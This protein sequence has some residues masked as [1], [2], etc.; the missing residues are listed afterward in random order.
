M[1]LD[2]F[3]NALATALMNP[4]VQGSS[5]FTGFH[6]SSAS[7]EWVEEG[8]KF[9]AGG[10]LRAQA[11][12][13]AGVPPTNPGTSQNRFK[14]FF[15]DCI[16][17]GI[18]E[19]AKRAGIWRGDEV[20]FF[21]PGTEELPPVKGRTDL[22]IADPVSN[23]PVGVEVKSSGGYYF[24]KA[25]LGSEGR[26]KIED[27]IQSLLYLDCYRQW[28][29]ALWL[30]FYLDREQCEYRTYGVEIG[31]GEAL[32]SGP[33]FREPWPHVN[34]ASIHGRW[35]RLRA[36]IDRRELPNR[37]YADQW[38]NDRIALEYRL[39]RLNQKDTREVGKKLDA[40][41]TEEPLIR[42]GDWNCA[43]CDHRDLCHG[44]EWHAALDHP[45]A[46]NP[47]DPVTFR[48]VATDAM[49]PAVLDFV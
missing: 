6:P 31:A 20:R 48:P 21:V 2:H 5:P 11:Y 8:V 36:H 15:G 42:K 46:A 23:R 12:V 13:A 17:G 47:F 18:T 39:G 9:V 22:F 1:D 14:A 44:A 24:R 40:G 33:G 16:H 37:D 27:V 38:T 30:L 4:P 34:L 49:Q 43:Y 29:V 10:C 41:E 3:Q 45:V 7:V 25:V 32:V 28:D 26:P 19:L 35:Q